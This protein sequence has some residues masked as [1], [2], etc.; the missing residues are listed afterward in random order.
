MPILFVMFVVVYTDLLSLGCV[1]W[2]IERALKKHYVLSALL[3]LLA[4]SVRQTNILWVAY[5]C[6][7]I[8]FQIEKQGFN[9]AKII[10][11]LKKLFPY[12]PV[13]LAFLIFVILNKGIPIGDASQHG[14]S[15]NFAAVHFFL[16]TAFF[17]FLL[18]NIAALSDIFTLLRRYPWIILIL[19]GYYF[20]YDFTYYRSHK[21]NFVEPQYFLRNAVLYYSTVFPRVKIVAFVP[22]AWMLLTLI[23]EVWKSNLKREWFLLVLFGLLSFLP[24]PLIDQRYYLVAITFV[25]IL[26]RQRP[27]W[28]EV[29][30]GVQS[31]AMAFWVVSRTSQG[32][33]FL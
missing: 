33:F 11:F 5:C 12:Y 1:L 31:A 26:A 13:F 29:A 32:G 19:I 3:A 20:L 28:V 9:R 2:M 27:I 7:L 14:I 17:V 8:F 4:I 10:R 22:I 21:Y 6:G 25:L 15:V 24:L 16:L 23:T 30:F 18:R